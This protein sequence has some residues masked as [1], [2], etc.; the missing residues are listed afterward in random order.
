MGVFENSAGLILNTLGGIFLLALLL[1]FLLQVAKADFYN[2]ISQAVVKLTDPLVKIFR[3]FIP[4]YRGIDFSVLVL[5]ILV[6][7]VAICSLFFIYA[8]QIPGIND[9]VTWAFVGVIYFIINIYYYAIIG[10]IIMSFVMMFSGSTSP[11][12]ILRLIWQLTEPV[13][14]PI[15]KIVPPMGG[16]DF[17]PIFI[18][19]GIQL[20][21]NLL[22]TTFNIDA[23][24]ALVIIGI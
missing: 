23:R 21:R 18:F 2:P 24:L 17:S 5:A 7:A 11:H 9:I 10:S 15:R 22:I 12:P 14:G 4:G 8:G 3:G 1:R 16:L 6:E 20:I 13:M 19:I